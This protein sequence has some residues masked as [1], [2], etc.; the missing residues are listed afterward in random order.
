[1]TSPITF[2]GL[3]AMGLPMAVN[4]ATKQMRVTGYDRRADAMAHLE[5]AGGSSAA[6]AAAAAKGASTLIVM[7]VNADQAESV[8]FADGALA[9]L[10]PDAIVIV[11]ATCAPGR[12]VEIA[13]KVE[14]TGRRFI[15]APVSGGVGGA[16]SGSLTIMAAS[17]RS[18]PTSI[19]SARSPAKVLR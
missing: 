7:V 16:E 15:D 6:S 4:L 11:M 10:A 1:M 8:L 13:A 19:T 17:R 14:A 12:I 3:G 2:I 18:A 5:A 9:A